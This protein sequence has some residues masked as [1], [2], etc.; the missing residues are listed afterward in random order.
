MSHRELTRLEI[1][2]RVEDRRLNQTQ[3]ATMLGMT[4]RQMWRLVRSYRAQGPE[5]LVSKNRGKIG[6]HRRPEAFK[7]HILAIIRERYAD[8][9]PTLAREKLLERHGLLVP[10]ETLRGRMRD[11]GIWLPRAARRKAIQQPRARRQCFGE[12]IQIDGSE[13]HWFEDRG[14]YC[15]VL[16]YVDDATSRLQLL[17]FVEGESTFDYMQATKL[18]IERWRT[19]PFKIGLSRRCGSKGFRQWIKPTRGSISSWRA[20]TRAFPSRRAFP[21][22]RIDR[23]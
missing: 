4:P 6:N 7:D 9:G 1:L 21:S 8:F 22:L 18:Y 20:I 3:A 17:R 14:P 15:S 12:L 16:T 23:F 13:H 11:A 19:E 10:C 2:Q 5:G